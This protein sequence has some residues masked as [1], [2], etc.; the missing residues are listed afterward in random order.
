MRTNFIETQTN[1]RFATRQVELVCT[2]SR[3]SSSCARHDTIV[4][5]LIYAIF[6]WAIAMAQMIFLGAWQLFYR[7]LM[8]L[9]PFASGFGWSM[10]GMIIGGSGLFSKPPVSK[11]E[12]EYPAIHPERI[13][14]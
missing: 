4:I 3:I 6:G 14:A 2:D 7:E 13:A 9:L 5:M 1:H 12:P 11:K 10:I 8:P